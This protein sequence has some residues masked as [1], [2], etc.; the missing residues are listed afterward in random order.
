MSQQLTS[1]T[2]IT[3][4]NHRLEIDLTISTPL[5]VHHFN[6]YSYG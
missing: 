6:H 5:T 3:I 1:S 4:F 2:M